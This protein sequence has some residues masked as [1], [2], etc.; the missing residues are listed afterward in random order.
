MARLEGFEPPA[1]FVAKSIHFS[2]NHA[3]L[4]KATP[5]YGKLLLNKVL[6]SA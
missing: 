5:K 6:L 4:T 3:N 1:W 2:L